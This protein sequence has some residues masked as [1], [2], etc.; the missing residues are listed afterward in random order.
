METAEII[1]QPVAV[2]S[3]IDDVEDI[4]IAMLI[5][6]VQ[7]MLKDGMRFVTMT[8]LD[9]GDTFEIFYHFDKNLKL[10]NLRIQFPH[11]EEI[12]SVTGVCLAAFLVENEIKEL[13]GVKIT[14][15]VI[16]YQNHLYLT[17]ECEP[18]PMAKT[19]LPS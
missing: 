2:A 8:C 9:H 14:D 19:I 3:D 12:P 18:A 6:T 16:D 11:D 13:F 5:E 17:E 10:Y 4:S 15:I 1:K 7:A